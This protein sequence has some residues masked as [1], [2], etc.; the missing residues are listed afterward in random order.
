MRTLLTASLLLLATACGDVK[1]NTADADSDGDGL[2]DAEEADLGTD[3]QAAD[4]DGDGIDDADEIDMGLDPLD[5]D[6]D[7]DGL[8]DA[9]EDEYGLDP[10]NDDYDGDGVLDGVE[11]EYGSKPKKMYSWPGDGIWPNFK[12][13]ADEAGADGTDYAEGEVFPNF[14]GKDINGEKV[15]LYHFYGNVVLLD[16]SAGWCGPC[17]AQAATAED[18]F[19]E[20][21]DDGFVIVHA[22][23]DDWTGG[24][25]DTDFLNEWA[26]EF[27][28]TF[29][30][31]GQGEID[32]MMSAAYSDGLYTGSIPF[33]VLLDR[34]MVVRE[35]YVGTTNDRSIKSAA[36][37]IIEEYEAAE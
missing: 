21:R 19:E 34:E 23:A 3:P 22:M 5:E 30:V 12:Y 2:T 28:L 4:S 36:K 1:D 18:L 31:L 24:A 7:G 16:F 33:M 35:V 26:E 10:L 14:K 11:I 27:G 6:S 25:A 13:L 20:L 15:Q 8:S 32:Q 9:E 37:R 17:Q 29:P